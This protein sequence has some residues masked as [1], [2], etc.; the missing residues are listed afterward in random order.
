MKVR[1]LHLLSTREFSGAENVVSQIIT[2]FRENQNFEMY[3]VSPKGRIGDV[4]ASKGIPYIPISSLSLSEV[5]RVV[6][7]IKPDI[8]HTHD[9][10][11]TLV[12]SLCIKT[13][14]LIGTIHVNDIRMQSW[15]LKSLSFLFASVR[16]RHILWVSD[17]SLNDYKFCNLIKR[18]S[19]ILRNVVNPADI[20]ELSRVF[21]KN[22]MNY[23]VVF[24][25]RLEV[26]KNP[27][28]FLS[29]IKKLVEIKDDL[30]VAI[31]GN[32]SLM[33]CV[34][35]TSIELNIDKNIDFWGS[36]QNPYP[37]LSAS[38][39]LLMTSRWEG[40]PMVALEAMA[41]GVPIISTP[42][43]GMCELVKDGVNGYLTDDD[44]E[45]VSRVKEIIKNDRHYASL[46]D[47]QLQLNKCRND[48]RSYEDFLKTLYKSI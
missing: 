36:V 44:N 5:R 42:T 43:D 31:V 41:L 16:L 37:I 25:G 2:M 21:L 18:K 7:E 14:K 1:I 12:A 6:R 29:I 39:L 28:R 33:K 9:V 45:F 10:R 19:S 4:L 40:T 35:K 27:L 8:V 24:I 23:D 38:K 15:S 47:G 30:K 34:K 13:A 46:V 22:N 20:I 11:A 48:I 3:Y 32:G 17:S 26:Q